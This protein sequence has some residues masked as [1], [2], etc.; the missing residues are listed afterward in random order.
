MRDKPLSRSRDLTAL[1]VGLGSIGALHRA[2][3]RELGVAVETVSR[4]A[5]KGSFRSV[6]E[7]V[8][9]VDPDYVVVATET[10]H[11]LQSLAEL[12]DTGF[13]GHVLV[14]KPYADQ[15]VEPL[16]HEFQA[17]GVGYNLRFH[18][19]VTVFRSALSGIR[20]LSAQVRVGSYLP[21][22]RP[23]QD[24]RR[25]S[26][27]GPGGG[28]LL[29]LSHE[30]DLVHWL[31]GPG[32]VIFGETVRSGTLEINNEDVA[33]G[34]IELIEG[35]PVCIEMNYLDRIP[36]RTFTATTTNG[37]IALDLITGCCTVDGLVVSNAPVDR[38][39]TYRQ[40]HSAM[41]DDDP[42]ICSESE[43][44]K[45]MDWVDSLRGAAKG[46]L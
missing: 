25:T 41:L 38:N 4:R 15:L 32:E 18:P 20:V 16:A 1:I 8:D 39:Y 44:L 42:D 34:V 19:S 5:G 27:A 29:D 9:A 30:L 10:E 43:A 22:W 28:V 7:A 21:E 6:A 37:T 23:G 33:V 2:V 26:S 45:V 24:Y 3:L 12:V 17:L 40:M 14:E 11:H 13:S 31:L 46:C 36:V 35:G